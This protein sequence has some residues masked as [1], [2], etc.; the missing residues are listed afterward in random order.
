[1]TKLP[2]SLVIY[3]ILASVKTVVGNRFRLKQIA[4][5]RHGF[6]YHS[7]RMKPNLNAARSYRAMQIRGGSKAEL[8]DVIQ[9]YWHL[10]F[11]GFG[12]LSAHVA[13]IRQQCE[14]WLSEEAFL[15][16]V[17]AVQTIP[18]PSSTQLIVA[19]AASHAGYVGAMVAFFMWTLPGFLILSLMGMTSNFPYN[20]GTPVILQGIP[21]VVLGMTF[22]STIQSISSFD[23]LRRCVAGLSCLTVMFV[24][25]K[26]GKSTAQS[27]I[28]LVMVVGGLV[29]GLHVY[30]P[31]IFTFQD[32]IV[33]LLT[34]WTAGRGKDL[35]YSNF[36]TL[37]ESK[38]I[39]GKT[40]SGVANAAEY[41]ASEYMIYSA[42]S[43]SP[44]NPIF[45]FGTP[46]SI[47]LAFLSWLSS[48]AKSL[49]S[50]M[51]KDNKNPLRGGYNDKADNE[52][53][54][55]VIQE[56]KSETP[57]RL[58]LM[59]INPHS[60]R[61]ISDAS[62]IL[63][64]MEALQGG[65]WQSRRSQGTA[66]DSPFIT[67]DNTQSNE[68]HQMASS[69]I[70]A[71]TE[72]LNQS[73]ME[74]IGNTGDDQDIGK[75]VNWESRDEDGRIDFPLLPSDLTGDS[76]KSFSTMNPLSEEN[77]A[78]SSDFNPRKDEDKRWESVGSTD[79]LLS[80]SKNVS[81]IT[82]ANESITETGM[83]PLSDSI[84]NDIWSPETS[85]NIQDEIS[86]NNFLD[87]DPWKDPRG[88]D[89][90]DPEDATSA[91]QQISSAASPVSNI[92]TEI[93]S[94]VSIRKYSSTTRL[95]RFKN[96]EYIEPEIQRGFGGIPVIVSAQRKEQRSESGLHK[97]ELSNFSDSRSELSNF[98]Q[99][100][101]D[102]VEN[103][104]LGFDDKMQVFDEILTSDPFHSLDNPNS[105]FLEFNDFFSPPE[106]QE[107]SMLEIF[108]DNRLSSRG[109][110]HESENDIFNMGNQST[111]LLNKARG[112]S[113]VTKAHHHMSHF[114]LIGCIRCLTIWL[115]ILLFTTVFQLKNPVYQIF[116]LNYRIGSML[117]GGGPILPP[118]F[119]SDILN[120]KIAESRFF[121]G[122]SLA[123]VLPGTVFNFA[124]FLGAYKEGW[125]GAIAAYLGIFTPGLLLSLGLVPLWSQVRD[126]DWFRS[127]SNGATAATS[128]ALLS[129]CLFN[130]GRSI[131]KGDDFMLFVG[132]IFMVSVTN[133]RAPV[134]VTL[135]AILG[136][137][138]Y[139]INL[140]QRSYL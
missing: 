106:V 15:E 102:F 81:D 91:S 58:S 38:V 10:G 125:K 63:H 79:L 99:Y 11:I 69:T 28:P 1:M 68:H 17:A 114:S 129:T 74:K 107:P 3:T 133:A 94:E 70:F 62:S 57:E 26:L 83:L 140:D 136:S 36:S 137:I 20:G 126:K 71:G 7:N 6:L 8:M 64:D 96:E 109:Q 49:E 67:L 128:G 97:P 93:E 131:Q 5:R 13:M 100:L 76:V 25:T 101:D 35:P 73:Q 31:N 86:L 121:L 4:P 21:P 108:G 80:S 30:G 118:L 82:L 139:K 89:T 53:I 98:D 95:Q 54:S 112:G 18:G 34:R 84:S 33:P 37:S 60:V 117:F 66:I 14:P 46:H 111:G 27:F 138:A 78:S 116:S 9:S 44:S 40:N 120:R 90:L 127:F 51:G 115:A 29:T 52:S 24:V 87:I 85:L 113:I 48:D 32:F 72:M 41:T 92:L 16:L 12:G 47:N 130:Y 43:T 23:L 103:D 124:A 39:C 123:Q 19:T 65:S 105:D 75:S 88:L 2:Q 135:G 59:T 77:V 134:V 61:P 122:V 22:W 110:Q 55:F 50:V 104:L 56:E 132:T 42:I 119:A 45:S